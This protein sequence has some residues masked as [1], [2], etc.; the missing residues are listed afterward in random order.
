M[1]NQEL[2]EY[3]LNYVEKDRT[4]SAIMLTAGWG[5]GKS[6]YIQNELCPFLKKR[7]HQSIVVSLY[8]SLIHI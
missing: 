6:Y 4:K 1:T 8:L 3:I 7:E 2:N 5:T